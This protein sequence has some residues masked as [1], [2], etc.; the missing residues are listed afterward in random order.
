MDLPALSPGESY[1]NSWSF[2]LTYSSPG[3]FSVTLS[4]FWQSEVQVYLS[5]ETATR[6]CMNVDPGGSNE[7]AC[8]SWQFYYSD[9]NDT[10]SSGGSFASQTINIEVTAT[11]VPEPSEAVLW[12]VGLALGGARL[13]RRRG[14]LQR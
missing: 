10:Y 9:N 6:D 8:S 12:L 3:Q 4:G 7:L 1:S 11:P 14:Y 5:S 2:P 13:A